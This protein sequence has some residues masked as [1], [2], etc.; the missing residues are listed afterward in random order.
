MEPL[1]IHLRFGT[2]Q[3]L[4]RLLTSQNKKMEVFGS[5]IMNS[6]KLLQMSLLVNTEITGFILGL[7]LKNLRLQIN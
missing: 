3:I 7:V 5:Q 2:I 6:N 1:M 4:L